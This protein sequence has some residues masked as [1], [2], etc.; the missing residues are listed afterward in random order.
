MMQQKS[1]EGDVA[2]DGK[3]QRDG[4][5]IALGASLFRHFRCHWRKRFRREA[6]LNFEVTH[7]RLRLLSGEEQSLLLPAPA[8]R[9]A[10][11]NLVNP[12]MILTAKAGNSL[13][14]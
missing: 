8:C 1:L 2:N 3:N 12:V 11:R 7:W 9:L 13:H 10:L 14:G 4:A 5:T 6:P